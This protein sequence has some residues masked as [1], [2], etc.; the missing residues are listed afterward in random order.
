MAI[1][2]KPPKG[3]RTIFYNDKPVGYVEKVDDPKKETKL[4][5]ALL[6]SKGLW[7]ETTKPES[8]YRQAE[9]FSHVA[10]RIY[11]TDLA[12]HP[13]NP[14]GIV[15]FVVNAAFSAE[16]Y[17]KCLQSIYGEVTQSHILTVL[18]KA[19]DNRTKDK[20]NKTSK[21]LRVNYDVDQKMLFRAHLKGIN[22]AFVDWR[23]IY[24]KDAD[25]IDIQQTIFVL[26]VLHETSVSEFKQLA[27]S[28]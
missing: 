22:D 16:M 12:T 24:E 4:A 25:Y 14:L 15:P 8:I 23:Y 20:I 6:K 17:L 5:Q 11:K 27:E 10:L 3:M 26:H 1:D 13:R 2:V 28:D 21:Q 7:R 19:L 9:S 18:F